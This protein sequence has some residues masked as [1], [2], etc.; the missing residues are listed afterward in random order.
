[1][2]ERRRDEPPTDEQSPVPTDD[3]YTVDEEAEVQKRLEDLGY[4]E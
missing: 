2:P 4:V 3:Q 1:M